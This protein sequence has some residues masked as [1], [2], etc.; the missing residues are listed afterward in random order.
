MLTV[1]V[2]AKALVEV[3]GLALLGQG[4][5][6]VLAGA[7]R[8]QN[9]FYRVLKIV[10]SP[11]VKITR[12]ITP[13]AIP[14]AQIPMLAFVL[15]AGLWLGLSLEKVAMCAD[16]PQHPACQGVAAPPG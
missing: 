1:V 10:A 12:L 2:I 11:A 15:V 5:L 14:D 3:A 9:V 6:Y 4:L 13:R 7:G 8:E 16:A